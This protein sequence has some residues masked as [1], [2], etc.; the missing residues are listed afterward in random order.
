MEPVDGV[1]WGCL[2]IVPI[3]RSHYLTKLI[4]LVT[5][6]SDDEINNEVRLE[7]SLAL[8]IQI[9]NRVWSE[10]A[11]SKHGEPI[12]TVPRLWVNAKGKCDPAFGRTMRRCT[13]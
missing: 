7:C 2:A 11:I 5:L 3:R 1:R 8:G 9:S 6:N 10:P 12:S 13:E 4:P